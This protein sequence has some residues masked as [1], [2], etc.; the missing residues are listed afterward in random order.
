MGSRTK[1]LMVLALVV[2]S[3]LLAP[4]SLAAED[5]KSASEAR[6]LTLRMPMRVGDAVLAPGDYRVQRVTEGD[7]HVLVFRKAGK[8]PEVRVKCALAPLPQKAMQTQ[9]M[10]NL[11]Q[12]G[13]PVLV[14][15]IL[16][17]DSV[18]HVF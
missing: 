12:N 4:I 16:E 18:K 17:G 14:G 5:I 7:Q 3:V 9:Q 8:A 2:S 6:P 15:L 13:E 11:G 1:T 10:Y